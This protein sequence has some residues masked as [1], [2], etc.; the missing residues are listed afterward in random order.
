MKDLAAI[1]ILFI[2]YATVFIGL[3]LAARDGL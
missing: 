2:I 1:V 3:M